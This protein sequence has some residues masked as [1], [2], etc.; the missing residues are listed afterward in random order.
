MDSLGPGIEL[1]I[2]SHPEGDEKMVHSGFL[3]YGL[4]ILLTLSVL[5]ALP[6]NE[7][8]VEYDPSMVGRLVPRVET[9]IEVLKENL[10]IQFRKLDV[11]KSIIANMTGIAVTYPIRVNVTAEYILSN[12]T[13]HKLNPDI[14]FPILRG[15]PEEHLEFVRLSNFS[16][17]V[18]NSSLPEEVRRGI[19]S[20]VSVNGYPI[21]SLFED[22]RA[23][24]VAGIREWLKPYPAMLALLDD[25]GTAR[26]PPKKRVTSSKTGLQWLHII[27]RDNSTFSNTIDEF[28]TSAIPH[29]DFATVRYIIKH[30][31]HFH[32]T[33]DEW[34]LD[35]LSC[36]YAWLHPEEPDDV[37]EF[38]DLW[39]IEPL[40][41]HGMKGLLQN[42]DSSRGRGRVDW[43][44][45]QLNRRIDFLT[46]K[47]SLK[48]GG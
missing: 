15:G 20:K 47:L 26:H 18:I 45:A 1:V 38:L 22:T 28:L 13:S 39:G 6:A 9:D 35:C 31:W 37:K 8:T 40:F 4:C 12:P 27:E 16:V 30:Q 14:A 10:D 24:W 11:R 33:I 44:L 29:T 36:I 2:N 5:L 46:Y 25:Q 34:D 43:D 3:C 19:R 42:D 41:L 17:D 23:V 32:H 21:E 48:P 7:V